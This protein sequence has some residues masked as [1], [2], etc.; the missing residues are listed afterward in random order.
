M[1]ITYDKKVDAMYIYLNPKKKIT[2]TRE[3]A[4]GWIIDYA[5]KDIVGIEILAASNVLGSK[6]GLKK[7]GP[8]FSAAIP[9]KIR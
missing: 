7:A 5:G 1:K 4:D 6:L 2:E 8:D 3:M 9:H